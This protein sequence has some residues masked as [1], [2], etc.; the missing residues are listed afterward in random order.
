[1]LDKG[2]PPL[3]R[4]SRVPG[5]FAKSRRVRGLGTAVLPEEETR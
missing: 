5:I 2:G 4:D 3:S 1:M